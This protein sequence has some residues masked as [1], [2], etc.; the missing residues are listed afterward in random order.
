MAAR[1]RWLLWAAAFCGVGLLAAAYAGHGF[2]IDHVRYYT[3]AEPQTLA[4]AR[5][6]FDAVGGTVADRL[7]RPRY[8]S[9]LDLAIS[10]DGRQLYV[11]AQDS[12]E[13]LVVDTRQRQ[14]TGAIKVGR[15]PHSVLIGKAGK[16]AYVSSEVDDTVAVV[17]LEQQRVVRS[18][19]AGD[20]P[21]GL[22]LSADEKT[23]FTAN[24]LGDDISV[25]DVNK[26]QEVRRLD[27]GSNPYDMALSPDGST[28]LVT[29][30]RSYV[31][32]YPNPPTSEVTVVDARQGRVAAR[33]QWRNAHLLEGVAIAPQGDLA[34]VTLVRPKNL[35]PIL[36]VAQGWVM[37]NGIGVMYLDPKE[38][39]P[40]R[41]S[42]QVLLDD[43]TAYYA[44]PCSVVITPD[45]RYAFVSH[46]GVDLVTVVDLAKLRAV[47]RG[48]SAGQLATYSNHLGLSKRYVIKRIQT[49]A[50]PKGLAVSRDGRFV[51]VAERLADRVAVI[52]VEKLALTA[53][54]DLGGSRRESLQRRGERIFNS[55]KFTFQNQ[56][57][58]RSCH[59]NNHVDRL[60]Y[61]FDVDGVGQNILDNRTL[62]GINGTSPFKWNGKNT[63]IY[64]Q[65]GI[66]FSKVLMRSEPFPFDDLNAVV[67]F[68]YSLKNSPNRYRASNG[69][70]TPAQ[71]Q[72]KALFE[73]TTTK[74]GKPIPANNRC[75]TCHPPPF[76]TNRKR[77]EVGTAAATDAMKAFD[78]P[79]LNNCYQSA[80]YLHNGKAAT[81]EEIWTVFN[82]YD[83]HGFTS[84]FSKSDLNDL[85]EYLKVL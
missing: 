50:N 10:P 63:S 64:M 46:S 52:D 42:A 13:L 39:N 14:V 2:A 45:G 6:H 83:T 1:R 57:S 28:L 33:A 80:P 4:C 62:L 23:L 75:I 56:F 44:D 40:G 18:L 25:I 68:I 66:R 9:P 3:A 11:T 70:L 59:P 29:N 31:T 69:A 85:I 51:Y 73:R 71:L 72:G 16:L 65:C 76:F 58:C 30:Q 21:A 53:T 15:R 24:W 82:A 32:S 84:D 17:D 35:V 55:A 8:K 20:A 36:G 77:E 78:V 26:G 67:A 54:V 43:S 49:A 60:Q 38:G 27:A 12:D 34:L 47:L 61:D 37:T 5:C 41:Q 7:L 81:L 19:P 74:E 22:V 48:A 79:Q